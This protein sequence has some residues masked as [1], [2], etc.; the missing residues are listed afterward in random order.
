LLTRE[1]IGSEGGKGKELHTESKWFSC[2]TLGGGPPRLIMGGQ[3]GDRNVV[4]RDWR[5]NQIQP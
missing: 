1:D 3:G 2:R 4:G 5:G